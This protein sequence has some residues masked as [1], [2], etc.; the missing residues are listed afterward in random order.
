M[1]IQKVLDSLNSLYAYFL[2][3]RF[4]QMRMRIVLQLHFFLLF[5]KGQLL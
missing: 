3:V 2:V 1:R 5:P 4:E